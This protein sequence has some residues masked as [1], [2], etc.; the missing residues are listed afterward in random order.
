V[1]LHLRIA[2]ALVAFAAAG[3]ALATFAKPLGTG[4]DRGGYAVAISAGTGL[5]L[6]RFA[7][8]EPRAKADAEVLA[9]RD[10]LRVAGV[11]I[12]ARCR[13]PSER[14]ATLASGD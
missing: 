9:C 5:K 10:V 8:A 11:D 1:P 12:G 13:T 14:T 7:T 4:S 3:S 6:V 2:L